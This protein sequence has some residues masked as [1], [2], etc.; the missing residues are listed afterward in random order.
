MSHILNLFQNIAKTSNDISYETLENASI[1]LTTELEFMNDS[2]SDYRRGYDKG[3]SSFSSRNIFNKVMKVLAIG[4]V[5]LEL[6]A[7]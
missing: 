5:I 6:S 2:R 1:T 4:G 7:I 3:D